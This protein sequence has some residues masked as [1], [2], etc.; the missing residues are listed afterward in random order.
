MDCGTVCPI[1]FSEYTS[2]GN[3]RIMSLQCGHLFGSQ[4][5][6]KWIGKKSRM[7]C[8]LCS[9]KSTKRQI[10]PVYAS[11][12]V[13]ID[14]ENEQMLLERCLKEEKEK[15][16]YIEICAGLKAQVEALKAELSRVIE[17]RTRD[18][19]TIH[20]Q[21]KFSINVGFSTNNSIIEYDESSCTI[22]V[23]RKNGKE[24]GIQKFESYD[25]SKSEFVGLGEGLCMGDISLSPFNQG[26]G[27]F[28]IGNVLNIVNV[29]SG[30][31]VAKYTVHNKIEST[32][33]DKDDKNTVYCGDNRGSVYFINISSCE[34]FKALKVSNISI[35][36]IC[37]K[38]L[39]V[40][41]STIYQTY[42]IVFSG[43]HAPYYLEIEPY[44]ICTNMSEYKDHLLLTF[45]GLDFRVKHLICGKKEV[46][47]SLGVKQVKRHRDRIYR[48]YI[49]IVD[50]ERNSIRIIGVHS[51]EAIYT[52]T[53]K[54]KILDFFVCNTFLFVLTRFTI[55][56]FSNNT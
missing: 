22:V 37:K 50:D 21:K 1:C 10:R 43:S 19:F 33:F 31:I 53:F 35:H 20:K 2:T 16:E 28:P 23:T 46:Y 6:Q 12:I 39:E 27:L 40:F 52:Y 8:P 51:L 13:A 32:C 24:V 30:S 38:G 26:L 47:L 11:K 25:F 17:E 7:Q 56:I 5:I 48:D 18:A 42:K 9:I 3:H 41:A 55:H 29:Y 49:Y 45:R 15:N 4:C 14:T 44:S 34:P 36:S 54:E